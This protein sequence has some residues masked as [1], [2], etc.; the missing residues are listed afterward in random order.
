[1][2]TRSAEVLAETSAS[3]QKR[4]CRR[5]LFISALPH[6]ADINCRHCEVRFVPT[7]DSCSAASYERRAHLPTSS[8]R[9]S[10]TSEL[11]INLTAPDCPGVP[12]AERDAAVI[13]LA[14]KRSRYGLPVH[15][16][17]ILAWR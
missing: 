10:S 5:F 3:G 4:K 15:L 17:L 8:P 13:Q 16:W 2:I 6:K 14:P 9:P 1:M 11:V 7:T 12:R